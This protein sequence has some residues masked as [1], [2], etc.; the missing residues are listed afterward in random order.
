MHMFCVVM[1]LGNGHTS[2]EHS[3]ENCCR[4][5]ADAATDRV[6]MLATDNRTGGSK[7]WILRRIAGVIVVT[8][9][10]AIGFNDGVV[11][12]VGNRSNVVVAVLGAFVV[13]ELGRVLADNGQNTKI[14]RFVECQSTRGVRCLYREFTWR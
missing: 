7:R 10:T 3:I 12:D 6:D 13:R 14:D 8:P 1:T 9:L 11:E 2:L 4:D 5:L